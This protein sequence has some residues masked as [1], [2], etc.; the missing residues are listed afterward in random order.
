MLPLFLPNQDIQIARSAH[1]ENKLVFIAGQRAISLQAEEILSIG[2]LIIKMQSAL[3]TAS[4]GLRKDSP[5][6]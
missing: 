5:P 1:M 3:C 2:K 4:C 6:I